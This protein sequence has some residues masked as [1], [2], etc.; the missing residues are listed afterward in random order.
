MVHNSL[1]QFIEGLRKIWGSLDSNLVSQSQ[2][3][4][5]K[6]IRAPVS[7]SWLQELQS[8]FEGGRELY[9]DPTHGFVL[10][11]YRERKGL[12]RI[13]H[14][15]GNGW[16][17]YSVQ[18][19]EM[20]MGTYSLVQSKSDDFKIV[21]REKYRVL[22]GESRVYLPGDIHDTKCVSDSVLIIR[23][24]SVDLKEEQR[25]GRMHRYEEK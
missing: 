1:T 19:G 23:L 12:Y 15:H 9:R 25:M 24:A 20:E 4:L 5:E 21:L 18:N 14:D 6:L 16:V 22:A 10:L 2:A 3:L 7:E 8:D 11:A 17:I 13:P